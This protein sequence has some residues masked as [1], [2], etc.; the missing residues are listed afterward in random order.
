MNL[1]ALIY[2]MVDVDS[3][4]RNRPAHI[5]FL[6]ELVRTGKIECGWKFPGYE[7]GA[8]QGVLFCRASSQDEVAG[9]FANDPVIRT[10]ARTFEVRPAQ[11][12]EVGG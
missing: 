6:R 1:F 9:W 8:I 10:G 11:A 4:N 2:T 7:A 5:E 3:S 12:M